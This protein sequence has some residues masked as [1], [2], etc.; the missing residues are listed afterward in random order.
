MQS[1]EHQKSFLASSKT[2]LSLP[3][4]EIEFYAEFLE[5]DVAYDHYN[6]LLEATDWKQ[7]KIHVYGKT[8]PTPRLSSWV[9]DEGT[10]YRY[11]NMTMVPLPWTERLLALKEEV[12]SATQHQ[13]NSVLL[14]YYRDGQDSNGWHSDNETELGL[15]PV[16]ASLSLGAP[17]DF[18]LRHKTDKQHKYRISLHNGSLLIMRGDTQ[19]YW[20]HQIPKRAHAEGRINLTFRT[21][22]NKK[23]A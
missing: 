22:L 7:E 13:Y 4:A 10:D 16:I 1:R 11:S 5:G 3:D 23:N 6:H 8:H 15:K 2:K 18:D 12:E 19:Q 21:I 14:N 20:Q 17:R 9:G